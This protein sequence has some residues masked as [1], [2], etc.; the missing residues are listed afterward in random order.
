MAALWEVVGQA[1]GPPHDN[2]Q[3]FAFSAIV[4]SALVWIVVPV[5]GV[6]VYVLG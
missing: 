6:L 3:P 2:S 4:L 5:G 1:G